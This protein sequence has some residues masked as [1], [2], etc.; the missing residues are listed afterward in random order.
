MSG[1]M[2]LVWLEQAQR[3]GFALKAY[4][5]WVRNPETTIQRIRERVAEGGH[6]IPKA[7]ARRRF[8]KTIQNF[9]RIYRPVMTSWK[10]FQNES[11]GPRLVALEKDG[12]RILRD[13]KRFADVQREAGL[14]L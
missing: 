6:N 10:L 9:F 13:P 2:A 3:T 7:V 1:K 12:R 8:F 14:K 11:S 4:F 5:L